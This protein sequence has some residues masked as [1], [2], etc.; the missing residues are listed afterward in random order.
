MTP[1][2]MK[3]TNEFAFFIFALAL[4]IAENRSKSLADPNDTPEAFTER[5]RRDL[6]NRRKVRDQ[7]QLT[8]D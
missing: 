6:A 3:P 5:L 4:G 1:T 8:L 7:L 2:P